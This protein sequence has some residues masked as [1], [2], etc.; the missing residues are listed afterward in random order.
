ME[1][2][3][4]KLNYKKWNKKN[5]LKKYRKNWVSSTNL[6]PRILDKNN[7]KKKKQK[8]IIKLKTYN[9]ISTDKIEKKINLKKIK[10]YQS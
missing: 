5:N 8:A 7:K 2:L 9:L 3:S 6:Q 4:G 10:K 1:V